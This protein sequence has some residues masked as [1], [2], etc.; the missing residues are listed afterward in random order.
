[1]S[2]AS[3]FLYTELL[4]SVQSAKNNDSP[5]SGVDFSM[6]W[7]SSEGYF[8]PGQFRGYGKACGGRGAN[9]SSVV[10]GVPR[11]SAPQC[12]QRRFSPPPHASSFWAAAGVASGGQ[13]IS[14]RSNVLDI[15]SNLIP[16]WPVARLS[17]RRCGSPETLRLT[18]HVCCRR[19]SES[20]TV[21]R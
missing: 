19:S 11:C 6:P 7:Q 21:Q 15:R 20:N 2:R 10:R 5:L 9:P 17:L 1:M 3:W 16:R 4:C 12:R 8:W 18:G 13:P 14:Q